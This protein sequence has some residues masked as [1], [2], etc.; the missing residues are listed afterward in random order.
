MSAETPRRSQTRET[1]VQTPGKAKELWRLSTLPPAVAPRPR[2]VAHRAPVLE[3]HD[4]AGR[5]RFLRLY[6]RP[7][8]DHAL[9]GQFVMLTVARD[10][11]NAPV[12]PRPMAIY[13]TDTTAGTI[14]ILYGVV[15]AGTRRLAGFRTDET[16]LVV[17]PLGRWFEIGPDVASVLLIGRG[18]GTCSLT[19]VAQST[20]TTAV[21][22]TAVISARHPVALIGGDLYREFGVRALHE[23][24][25]DAGTS[26]PEALFARL[27]ADLDDAPP[28]LILTCGSE[29]LTR[30]CQ[31]LAQRWIGSTVQVSVEAHMACGLGYC[32]GCAS[33]ARSEGAESPLICTDGPVFEWRPG[34][35]AGRGLS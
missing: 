22:T 33:G 2:P 26:S 15:G 20:A 6:A 23:V 35:V 11:E 14:D 27:T 10:G 32:H 19:T 16:M 28:E 3:H 5:Y 17:G 8:A 9:P 21:T 30:L 1:T 31:Q 25:D 12:L 34:P 4:L 7:I 13:R 29:R 18:I 24:T